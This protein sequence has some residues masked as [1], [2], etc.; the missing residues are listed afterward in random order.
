MVFDEDRGIILQEEISE[1]QETISLQINFLS[2]RNNRPVGQAII[3]LWPMIEPGVNI[4][5]QEI[6]IYAYDMSSVVGLA[7]V[8]VK[9]NRLF[10]KHAGYGG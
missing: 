10:R 1:L 5:R 8:D 6:D 7:V 4:L 2:K 3:E 9:G